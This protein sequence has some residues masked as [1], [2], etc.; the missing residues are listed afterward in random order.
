MNLSNL[1]SKSVTSLNFQTFLEME[2]KAEGGEVGGASTG[3]SCHLGGHLARAAGSIWGVQAAAFPLANFYMP[4][5]LD[6]I[7]KD[8]SVSN[9]T[10][11]VNSTLLRLI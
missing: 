8:A 3:A 1:Q 4:N 10:D 2:Q 5:G 9:S 6:E 7:F 11:I